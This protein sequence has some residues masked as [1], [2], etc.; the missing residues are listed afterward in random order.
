M[1]ECF[2]A[3]MSTFSLPAFK[4][5]NRESKFLFTVKSRRLPPHL[6]VYF[7]HEESG[8]R[9]EKQGE[10][11]KKRHDGERKRRRA[12]GE[13]EAG[14]DA[15]ERFSRDRGRGARGMGASI[16]LREAGLFVILPGQKKNKL[17]TDEERSAR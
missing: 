15:T 7:I 3:E 12:E 6:H 16:R 13:Q 8:E 1:P 11:R 9:E 4:L 14:T 2:V 10:K 17:E 5:K